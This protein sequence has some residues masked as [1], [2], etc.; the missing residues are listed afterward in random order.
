M[1]A[2]FMATS[3]SP[4][5]GRGVGS[6]HTSSEFASALTFMIALM[7]FSGARGDASSDQD[8]AVHV[9]RDAGHP[10]RPSRSQVERSIG[11]V[12]RQPVA[13]N[14]TAGVPRAEGFRE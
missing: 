1:P 10:V 5:A 3:T 4:R 11:D 13:G 14:G 2:L 6:S 12:L 7:G 9:E 8:P